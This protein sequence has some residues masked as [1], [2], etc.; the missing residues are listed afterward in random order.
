MYALSFVDV[1]LCDEAGNLRAD[2]DVGLA[3]DSCRVR[4]LVLSRGG[5]DSEN[6]NLGSRLHA[7]L[8]LFAARAHKAAYSG[9]GQYEC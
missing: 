5:L 1:Y 8:L 3:F 4:V 9:G 6:G 2:I 7:G